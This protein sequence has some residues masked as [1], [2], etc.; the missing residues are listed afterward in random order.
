MDWDAYI[1]YSINGL[2]GHWPWVDQVM[3]LV[4]RPWTYLIPGLVAFAFWYW[5][6]RRQ[7]LVLAFVLAGLITLTDASASGVKQ[8]V[9]RSRPCQVLENVTRVTGCGRAYGFPS[10]HA[11]NTAS[12][13]LFFQLI[14]PQTAVVA[15]PLVALVG[16]NRVYVGAH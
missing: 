13:A 10:N 4:S 1:F 16:F 2:A 7:A 12:A 3:R 6:E 11:V 5:K 9:A 15:W 14:Y 8:L